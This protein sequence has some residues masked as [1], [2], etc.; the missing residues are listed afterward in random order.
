MMHA[1]Y[2]ADAHLGGIVFQHIVQR[3]SLELALLRHQQWMH[4]SPLS[5]ANR[6]RCCV[7]AFDLESMFPAEMLKILLQHNPPESRHA[8]LA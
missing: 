3:M 7:F 2:G 8:G 6:T 4:R 1:K 5:G